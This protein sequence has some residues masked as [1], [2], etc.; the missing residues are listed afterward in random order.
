[1]LEISNIQSAIS[2]AAFW[3]TLAV[4]PLDH[5]NTKMMNQFENPALNRINYKGVFDC[6]GKTLLN[7]TPNAFWVGAYP[8]YLRTWVYAF[9]VS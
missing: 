9:A 1:M 6:V 4:L 7:E 3:G 5:V 2:I 8:F